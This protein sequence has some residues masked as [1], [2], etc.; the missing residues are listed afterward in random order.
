MLLRRRD[1]IAR[2]PAV[3]ARFRTGRTTFTQLPLAFVGW[4]PLEFNY[5]LARARAKT[6]PLTG[7]W[8]LSRERTSNDVTPRLLA[9][10]PIPRGKGER[11]AYNELTHR[12]AENVSPR[13]E[14][15][16]YARGEASSLTMNEPNGRKATRCTFTR[17]GTRAARRTYTARG[18]RN[19]REI[20]ARR[21]E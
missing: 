7:N 20:F 3:H 8:Y 10:A 19:C 13:R 11:D 9:A 2:A 1:G 4:S 18:R 14:E 21:G 15:L 16:R 6:V 5:T 17:T 12:N